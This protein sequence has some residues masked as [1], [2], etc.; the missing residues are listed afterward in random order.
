MEPKLSLEQRTERLVQ[1]SQALLRPRPRGPE[2]AKPLLGSAPCSSTLEDPLVQWR[3]RRCRG[4][5]PALDTPLVGRAR[6]G[7]AAPRGS[8][9]GAP[10]GKSRDSRGALQGAVPWQSRDPPEAQRPIGRRFC[11]HQ[12]L[13]SPL[14]VSPEP[15]WQEPC[16]RPHDCHRTLWPTRSSSLDTLQGAGYSQSGDSHHAPRQISSSCCAP[17][18]HGAPPHGERES[19]EPLPQEPFWGSHDC[20]GALWCAPYW[21]SCDSQDALWPAREALPEPLRRGGPGL[22]S[23]DAREAPQPIRSSARDALQRAP[24]QQPLGPPGD[25]LLWMLRCH[26]RAVRGRLRAIE[27]LL[28]CPPEHPSPRWGQ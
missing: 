15:L 18:R 13:S 2:R 24:W 16:W 1:R 14:P 9:Q 11:P 23:G 7:S 5:E 25:P 8:L 10:P 6:L 22:R 27:T 21:K 17:L 3:L 12:G 28:E 20:L 4:E 19:H 26:R